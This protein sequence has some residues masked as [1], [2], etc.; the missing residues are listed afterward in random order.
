MSEGRN[1]RA[2]F[3]REAKALICQKGGISGQGGTESIAPLRN[4]E[5]HSNQPQCCYKGVC[6]GL[7]GDQATFGGASIPPINK[8]G[9]KNMWSKKSPG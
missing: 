4:V 5:S 9:L 6:L 8:L 2:G 1:F 7:V 3:F